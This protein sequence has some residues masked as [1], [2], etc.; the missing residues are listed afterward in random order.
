[1]GEG[2][3]CVCVLA[4]NESVWVFTAMCLKKVFSKPKQMS[5][6]AVVG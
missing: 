2:Y 1:V 6:V 5:T 4:V 3:V